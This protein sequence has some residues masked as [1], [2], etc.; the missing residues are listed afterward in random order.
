[1]GSLRHV[2]WQEYAPSIRSTALSSAPSPTPEITQAACSRARC[3]DGRPSDREQQ[4]QRDQ[5]R[6]DAKRLGHRE[7]ED[8][9]AKL[10]LRRRW[11]AQRSREILTEDD[12]DA[13]ASAAHAN[14]GD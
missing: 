10:A 11:I 6:E 13:D 9:V 14:A 2:R 1:A 4:Q 3:V 5:E 7:A 12:A 8:Q